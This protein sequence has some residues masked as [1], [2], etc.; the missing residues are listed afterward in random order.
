MFQVFCRLQ[1]LK[2]ATASQ[3]DQSLTQFLNYCF[4]EGLDVS[5]A[6]RFFAAVMEAYPIVGKTNLV[7]SR[8]ALKGWRN[9]D[10]GQQ[11]TPLAW[12]LVSNIALTLMRL[13]QPHVALCILT[14]FNTYIRPSEALKLRNQDVV[15]TSN[16]G[17]QWAINLNSSEEAE[18]SKVGM[19]DESILLDNPM[20]NYLGPALQRLSQG[21][22][23]APLFNMKYADLIHWRRTALMSMGLAQDF[24]VLYQLR[25][26]GASWDR[27]K[28]T[29]TTLEIKLRGR[30][31]SDASLE[32]LRQ[33]RKSGTTLR[34]TSGECKE[35]G[36]IAAITEGNGYRIFHPKAPNGLKPVLELFAGCASL[37]KAFCRLG[38]TVHAYDFIW[39]DGGDVLNYDVFQKLIRSIQHDV[40]LC[41]FWNALR[42]VV[43]S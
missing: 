30:W 36:G 24:A 21:L 41:P 10:P 28:K 8:R 1:A 39:G 9:L 31:S 19:E 14:M 40:F 5:E 37:S 25:H 15:R 3:V 13:N 18:T 32:S 6:N 7:R 11:R 4:H 17:L 35:G 2:T 26:S 20:M 43:P 29:R 34:E 22:P 38:F 33:P 12:P 27:L 16:L 42:V 23:N